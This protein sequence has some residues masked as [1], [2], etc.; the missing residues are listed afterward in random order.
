VKL[1][2]EEP[3]SAALAGHLD[4]C[5]AL[6]AT[7]AL[8][9]IEVSRAV[10]VANADPRVQED[11][12]R[13]LASCMLVTV[14]APLLRSARTIASSSVRTLDAIHL[15]SAL[16]VEADALLVYDQRL[17]DAAGAHGLRTLAPGRT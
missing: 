6:L 2:I 1:V 7:S 5:D 16:R 13:L 3:H 8:A 15:A 12:D 4:E 11:V 10:A 14:T 17:F 9:E